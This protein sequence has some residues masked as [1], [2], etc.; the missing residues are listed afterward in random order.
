VDEQF[1]KP[2]A[3]PMWQVWKFIWR[4]LTWKVRLH[5]QL[6]GAARGFPHCQLLWSQVLE[7]CC[8]IWLCPE[9][10]RGDEKSVKVLTFP[11]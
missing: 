11:H 6:Q 4:C 9:E 1:G 2:L 3:L 8:D 10:M 5:W 7:Q